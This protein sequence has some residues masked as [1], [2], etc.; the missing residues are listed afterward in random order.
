MLRRSFLYEQVG[1]AIRDFIASS[2]LKQGD[3]LPSER[4]LCETLG[5]SRTSLREGLRALS[6]LGVVEVRT[7][8]GMFVGD[9]DFRTFVDAIPASML[10]GPEDV[11]ALMEIRETL[12]VLAARRA[13]AR[14]TPDVIRRLE[15]AVERMEEKVRT[16][17]SS[18][19]ED[20]EFHDIILHAAESRLLTQV[21]GAIADLIRYIRKEGLKKRGFSSQAVDQHRAIM[22]ALRGQDPRAAAEVM[23]LH[24]EIVLRDL[25]QF[26]DQGRSSS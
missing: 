22:E 10:D 21:L 18:L 11:Q 6:M 17:Q 8:Q 25:E 24:M 14:C 2:R 3:A 9:V 20:I 7:G 5:V 26:Y 23:R 15:A 1:V 4:E 19:D 16:G 13:A 12:E